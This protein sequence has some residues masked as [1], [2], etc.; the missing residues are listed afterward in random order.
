[1]VPD[2]GVSLPG[3][4]GFAVDR[5]CPHWHEFFDDF[6]ADEHALYWQ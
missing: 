2:R 4:L 1:M 6:G 3:M 5:A